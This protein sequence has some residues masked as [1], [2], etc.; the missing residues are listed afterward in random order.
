MDKTGAIVN[1]KPWMEV[2]PF[3][4]RRGS[5]TIPVG[6]QLFAV[7]YLGVPGYFVVSYTTEEGA[8]SAIT[9]MLRDFLPSQLFKFYSVATVHDTFYSHYKDPR[10]AAMAE[11]GLPR[12]KNKRG[13]AS[14]SPEKRKLIASQGGRAAHRAGVA[15]QWTQ[16]EA[17][18]AGRKGGTISRGGRGRLKDDQPNMATY[19]GDE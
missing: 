12:L 13:F 6:T 5:P 1:A 9:N 19:G 17:R 10:A 7:K 11:G 15:H 14:M 3:T 16:E 8:R 2:E 18:E 4:A